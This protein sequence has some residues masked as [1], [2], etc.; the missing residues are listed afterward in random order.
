MKSERD[1]KNRITRVKRR[2]WRYEFAVMREIR[3]K[4]QLEC[5][6]DILND[7][8][9]EARLKRVESFDNYGD[10]WNYLF[11]QGYKIAYY[12]YKEL[13]HPFGETYS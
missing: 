7:S 12:W 5:Y 2:D 6:E 8:V 4:G 9:D 11:D 10:D 3:D 1:I 13:P